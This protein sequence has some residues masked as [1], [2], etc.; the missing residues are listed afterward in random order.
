MKIA[1]YIFGTSVLILCLFLFANTFYFPPSLQPTLPG[2]SFWPRVCLFM[3]GCLCLIL[4]AKNIRLPNT[5][6]QFN[7]KIIAKIVFVTLI[8]LL[9]L[10]VIGYY[11]ATL[12]FIPILM[13]A[14]GIRN[15]ITLVIIPLIIIALL[16]LSFEILLDLPLI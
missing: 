12:L 1:N 4:L 7:F 14:C 15:L 9:F 2:P 16:Y 3:S 5:K 8:Y 13:F 6:I 10:P 11:I